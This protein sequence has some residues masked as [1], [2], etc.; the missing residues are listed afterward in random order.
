MIEGFAALDADVRA[1][2]KE[3]YKVIAEA[4]SAVHG[5][6]VSEIHFH[7]VGMM[8]AIMDVTAVC[9]LMHMI[10]PEYVAASPVRVGC[11]HVKCAH[12]ILPVPA[13]A[14]ARILISVPTYAGNIRAELCTPTG[15]ALLKH[16][17]N[18]FI[19]QPVMTAERIGY[20]MGSKDFDV[21]NCIR[22]ISGE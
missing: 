11:G 21:C 7:E 18:E 2:I 8:D 4:E 16:Y 12:G 3:V 1:D 13:P 5:R 22:A 19:E 14:T 10:R 6:E 9:L 17:V 15:A 20:G